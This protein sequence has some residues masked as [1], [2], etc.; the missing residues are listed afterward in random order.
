MI[1][2]DQLRKRYLRT[3]PDQRTNPD[4]NVH[5]YL[6]QLVCLPCL[7]HAHAYILYAFQYSYIY[8]IEESYPN[9]RTVYLSVAFKLIL[10]F[11]IVNFQVDM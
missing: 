4:E 10:E 7:I 8:I 5:E 1:L 2:I 11:Q 9:G 6:F 3:N